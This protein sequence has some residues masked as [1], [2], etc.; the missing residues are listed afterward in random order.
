MK[1][2]G[3]EKCPK[4]RTYFINKELMEEN[5]PKLFEWSNRDGFPGLNTLGRKSGRIEGALKLL[6]VAKEFCFLKGACS[7]KDWG[8]VVNAKALLEY[9]ERWCGK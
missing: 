2:I 9:L 4:G 6:E 5:D 8:E 7:G 1:F 3:S